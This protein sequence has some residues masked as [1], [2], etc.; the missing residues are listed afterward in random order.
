MPEVECSQPEVECSQ[1]AAK[2]IAD[3]IAIREKLRSP[4]NAVPDHPI[5]LRRPTNGILGYAAAR[6]ALERQCRLE[7]EAEVRAKENAR[8]E[9][10]QRARMVSF[11]DPAATRPAIELDCPLTV[12]DVQR[13]M[14]R[15]WPI[16]LIELMA[17]RRTKNIV[18][19]RQI[20]MALAKKLTLSSLPAIGRMFDGMD[21]TTVLH[22]ARKYEWLIERV[23]ADL[24][25]NASLA[26]WVARAKY[27]FTLGKEPAPIIEPSFL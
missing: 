21:H 13:E 23:A 5:S 12:R 6:A 22:A 24:P 27:H 9:A 11:P 25:P 26:E 16:E 10:R 2:I 3:A 7:A 15:Q 8:K 18:V 20:T 14:A 1:T 19:P 4:P 17:Q